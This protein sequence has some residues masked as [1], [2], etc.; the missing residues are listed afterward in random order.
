MNEK[1]PF[2]KQVISTPGLVGPTAINPMPSVPGEQ[3]M[4]SIDPPLPNGGGGG[5]GGSF[6]GDWPLK[7]V[8]VDT[9]NV[10]VLLGTVNGGT[11]T[12]INTNIDVSGT[13][14]T[15]AIYMH[16]SISGTTASSPEV[17]SDNT[18]AVPTDTATDSY[19]L[20][21]YVTVASSVITDVQP[22]MAWSQNVSICTADTPPFYWTTGS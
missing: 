3:F 12:G 11:P 6:D 1:W 7:L 18:G 9:E 8:Q 14:A 20:I 10:K 19:R 22:S 13:D 21:G 4:R 16:V 2:T 15:W 5:G 17:L